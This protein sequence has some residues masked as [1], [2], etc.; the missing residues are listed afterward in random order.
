MLSWHQCPASFT[1]VSA[2]T[3]RHCLTC[4]NDPR[5][6]AS[7]LADQSWYN[8][9]DVAKGHRGFLDGDFVMMLY[10]WSP[11]WRLN[12]MGNDRYELYIRRSFDGG[13][14]LDDPAEQRTSYWDPTT[15]PYY[16]RRHGHLRDLPQ[17][18]RPRPPVT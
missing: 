5:T 8:P 1:T 9:L 13:E 12:A 11:N 14:H 3:D 7:T 17:R 4:D 18:P 2:A 10:A 6:D 15:R 16:R